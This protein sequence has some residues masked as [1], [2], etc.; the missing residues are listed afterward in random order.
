MGVGTIIAHYLHSKG[1]KPTA[2]CSCY[3]L[4]Q[5]MDRTSPES[6]K[7]NIDEW[8]DRMVASIVEWR[9]FAEKSWQKFVMPPRFTVKG[10]ILWACNESIKIKMSLESGG[11][12]DVNSSDRVIT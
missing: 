8:T 5:E 2:G 9:K 11:H 6:I 7:E 12:N 4:A 1:I 3:E 10:L